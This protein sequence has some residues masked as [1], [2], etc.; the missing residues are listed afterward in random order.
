MIC[1]GAAGL[2]ICNGD[3][4]GPLVFRG[5]LVGIASWGIGCAD[6]QHPG[7]YTNI[8]SLKSFITQV[9]GVQ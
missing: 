8:A 1:A 6:G 3:F 9:T 7:V 5:Q 2:G 4:G